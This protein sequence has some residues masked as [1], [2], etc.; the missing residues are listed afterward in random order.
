V[1]VGGIYNPNQHSSHWQT[2]LSMGTLDSPVR[3]GHSIVHCPMRATSN[4]CWGLELLTVEVVCPFGAPDSPVRSSVVVCL[5][6]SDASDCCEV[7]RSRPLAESTVAPWAHQ[8]DRCTSDSPVNF[9]RGALRIP[10]SGR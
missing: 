9:S 8:T 7:D 3:T 2:S 4:N 5:L 10:D 1:V 6:T